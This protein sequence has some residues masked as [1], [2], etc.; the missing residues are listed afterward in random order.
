M[1]ILEAQLECCVEICGVWR[2]GF[3]VNHCG[4]PAY[5]TSCMCAWH[6]TAHWTNGV[7]CCRV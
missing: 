2:Y 1:V 4:I 3:V 6:K 7:R 5:C